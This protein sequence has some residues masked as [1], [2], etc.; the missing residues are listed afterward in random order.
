MICH[1]RIIFSL[2]RLT[3]IAAGAARAEG[4]NDRLTI[5]DGNSGHVIYDDGREG[6]FCVT[7]RHVSGLRPPH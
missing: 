6:L 4:S 2:A 3:S 5:G 7:H 1:S